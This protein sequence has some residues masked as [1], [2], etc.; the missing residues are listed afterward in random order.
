MQR[1]VNL[2]IVG[3]SVIGLVLSSCG[4]KGTVGHTG[5][6]GLMG[7]NGITGATGSAGTTGAT[8]SAGII[9]ATGSA[10]IT[11]VTGSTGST[12][13]TGSTGTTG[14]TGSAGTTG[15][16]G[17]PGATGPTGSAPPTIIPSISITAFSSATGP[18][19]VNYQCDTG[20]G[21]NDVYASFDVAVTAT[22]TGTY[23]CAWN[24]N[25]A[26]TGTSHTNLAGAITTLNFSLTA[27]I[28]RSTIFVGF[29]IVSSNFTST[30]WCNQSYLSIATSGNFSCLLLETGVT[31]IGEIFLSPI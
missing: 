22:I 30:T 15:A 6:M 11:G 24:V 18:T 17:N 1:N 27:G 10:G 5:P 23:N 9:G 21:D 31:T 8:G 7:A 26:S 4:P 14:V 25:I 19:G 3:T 28:P 2:G 12:G 16:T 29:G 13:A 20:S